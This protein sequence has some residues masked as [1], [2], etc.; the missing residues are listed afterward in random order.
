MTATA[1]NRPAGGGLHMLNVSHAFGDNKVVSG[2]SVFVR[3]GELV[4]LLGPSGCG[5]TTL[6]RLAAG[7][8][9]LQVGRITIGDETVADGHG[10]RQL[11]PEKR[12]VGLMF[13][14]FALFP[15]LTVFE[16]I[17]FG[18]PEK[19]TARR[20]WAR[21]TMVTMGL[22]DYADAFP[23]TLS[24]GQQ[25]RVALLRALAPA[26]RVLL[27]DEP[28]SGLDVNRR[29]QIRQDTF[30]ILSRSGIATLM[31]THDPEEAMFMA[32]RILVMQDGRIVQSGTPVEIYF[33]PQTDFV[34]ELFGPVNR[35]RGAVSQG[36]LVTP[37]GRFPANG[38]A[39]AEGAE[40]RVLVR[41]EALALSVPAAGD[42]GAALTVLSA[43]S[44]GRS[45]HLTLALDGDGAQGVLN[46]RM[47]GVFLPET[48]SRVT[49]RVAPENL[50]VFPEENG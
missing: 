50:L 3:P 34:A 16:N 26:P 11:A 9:E 30:Q 35:L 24:G 2:V 29:A 46:A 33:H 23:H 4:C 49:A 19:D 25:Q 38:L 18:L 27:L 43:R 32:D 48:G 5:K 20:A 40:V 7:L 1:T 37:L 13:Q 31:V 47:P 15:H 45:T 6:L 44:L 14:D 41:P 22:G 28:F 17:A 42:G 8:E 21:E 36:S 10:G 39:L 12:N